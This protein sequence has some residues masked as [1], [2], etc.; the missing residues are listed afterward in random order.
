LI[1]TDKVIVWDDMLIQPGQAWE[2][3]IKQA[4][5]RARV[6]VLLVSPSFLASEFIAENE[7]PPLLNAA[8]SKGLKIIW[9]SLSA[10]LYKDTEIAKYRAVHDPDQPLDSLADAERNRVLVAACEAIKLALD[11]TT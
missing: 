9:I 10:S 6:A 2:V 11:P 1:R 5:D 4:L 7:L 3:E 8:K